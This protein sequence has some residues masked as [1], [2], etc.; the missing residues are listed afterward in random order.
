MNALSSEP[1][2]T[3]PTLADEVALGSVEEG[4]PASVS[5]FP[6]CLKLGG[7]RKPY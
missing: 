3:A 4:F 6:T 7:M 5:S 2:E 1:K